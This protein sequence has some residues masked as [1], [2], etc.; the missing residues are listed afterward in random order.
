MSVGAPLGAVK[1]FCSAGSALLKILS[2]KL[3]LKVTNHEKNYPLATAKLGSINALVSKRLNDDV[4]TNREFQIINYEL[5]NYV[6]LKED[7][8]SKLKV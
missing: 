5:E 3:G 7:V 8:R 2:K 6:E 1:A 4:V